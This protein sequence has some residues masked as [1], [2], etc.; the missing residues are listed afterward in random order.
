M[1]CCRTSRRCAQSNR[2][3]GLIP[4]VRVIERSDT[5][6]KICKTDEGKKTDFAGLNAD[7]AHPSLTRY[8]VVSQE[9]ILP[10]EKRTWTSLLPPILLRFSSSCAGRVTDDGQKTFEYSKDFLIREVSRMG[11]R[12]R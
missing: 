1:R 11:Q 3:C 9:S 8:V 12:I 5:S 4:D 10:Q 7:R 6:G 2:G